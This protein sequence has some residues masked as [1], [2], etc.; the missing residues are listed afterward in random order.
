M[1]LVAHARDILLLQ[2]KPD[3]FSIGLTEGLSGWRPSRTCTSISFRGALGRRS[4][5]PIRNAK[6]AG[7]PRPYKILRRLHQL[8][9]RAH[10]PVQVCARKAEFLC[11][12]ALVALAF[13]DRLPNYADPE[14]VH[15]L[16]E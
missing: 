9:A 8:R 3:G 16:I 12:E 1:E 5:V 4:A 10:E 6:S 11:R 2:V 14:F 13:R 15:H 7:R